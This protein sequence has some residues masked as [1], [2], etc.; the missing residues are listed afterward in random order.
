ML[1]AKAHSNNALLHNP[2]DIGETEAKV[3]IWGMLSHTPPSLQAGGL[4][5]KS[6]TTREPLQRGFEW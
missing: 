6:Y 1:S 2:Y 3:L 5:P 4:C